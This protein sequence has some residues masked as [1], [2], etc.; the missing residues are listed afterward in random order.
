MRYTALLP[1]AAATTAVSA[2]VIPDDATAQQLVLGEEGPEEVDSSSSH[3]WDSITT[4]FDG[5]IQKLHQDENSVTEGVIDGSFDEGLQWISESFEL[6]KSSSPAVVE[7]DEELHLL[8]F[9]ESYW[10]LPRQFSSSG[11]KK[12]SKNDTKPA[13]KAGEAQ[14]Q[15]TAKA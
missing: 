14:A 11:G 3:W 6:L 4:T 1:L 10:E 5:L 13:W 2:F 8:P 7:D 12:H 15:A 9:A